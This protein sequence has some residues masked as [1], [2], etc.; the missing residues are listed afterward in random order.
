MHR[1]IR[2]DVMRTFGS[3]WNEAGDSEKL[4]LCVVSSGGRKRSSPSRGSLVESK[5]M[6]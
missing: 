4:W 1:Q 5:L 6:I 2:T 3:V